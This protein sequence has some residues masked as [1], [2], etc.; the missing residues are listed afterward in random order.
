MSYKSLLV[1][2]LGFSRYSVMSS[3]NSD[4]FISFP[5]WIPFIS[6][7]SIMA[8]AGTFQTMLNNKKE[9]GHLGIDV[10]LSGKPSVFHD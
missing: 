5:I 4:S 1:L 10:V 6:C 2:S 3:A 7:S 9:S 8:L